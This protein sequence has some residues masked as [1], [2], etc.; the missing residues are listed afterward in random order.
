MDVVTF[1]LP[2]KSVFDWNDLPEDL[3][4][5]ARYDL[6]HDIYK[7]RYGSCD[8]VIDKDRPF[9]ASCEFVAFGEVGITR[10][11]FTL[12]HYERNRSHVR[13]DARDDFII[14]INRASER[15]PV[16]SGGHDHEM[17][18]GELLFHTNA[19]PAK[20]DCE[21]NLAMAGIAIPRAR[22]IEMVPDAED[23][24]GQLLDPTT[25]S[26][27]HLRRMVELLLDSDDYSDDGGLMRSIDTSFI[28]LFAL[29]LGAPRDAAHLASSRGLRATR[30]REI[31]A[32]I[33]SRFGDPGFSQQEVCAK[34]DLSQRYVQELLQETGQG[35]SERVL[36]L[37]LLKAQRMLSN[38]KVDHMKIGDVAFASGF[39][40]ISYFNQAFR[41][42]FA[43]TPSSLRGKREI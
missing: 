26:A 19:D 13:A 1:K 22:I 17:K 29:V 18:F 8:F 43:T 42:R 24:L 21:T 15:L 20:C 37:R 41:R 23:R 38:K 34:L 30:T 11:D 32:M 36:E 6:W 40:D 31:I 25:A 16:A 35:F 5:R 39:S 2:Q 12:R 27:R 14:G 9:H 3:P 33:R 4:S 28:D 10:F 7:S